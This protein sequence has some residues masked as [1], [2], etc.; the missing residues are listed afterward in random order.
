MLRGHG[1]RVFQTAVHKQLPLINQLLNISKINSAVGN[2]DWR[3]GNINAYISMIVESY[4]DYAQSH[5]IILQF[6]PE[7][8]VVMDFVPD[9]VNKVINNLLSNALKFTPEYGKVSVIA[10]REGEQLCIDVADTGKGMNKEPMEHM[11]E[12]FYQGDSGTLH[13]GTGVGLALV[14]QIKMPTVSRQRKF[15]FTIPRFSACGLNKNIDQIF[16]V[17]KT[18]DALIFSY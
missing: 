5:N 16:Y 1:C 8:N 11:F 17:F 7:G 13:M 18:D 12:P 3:N 15:L 6:V 2:V 14:R 10:W 9:Y 4:R